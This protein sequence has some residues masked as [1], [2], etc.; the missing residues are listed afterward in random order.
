MSDEEQQQLA[1]RVSALE[2]KANGTDPLHPHGNRTAQPKPDPEMAKLSA[3]VGRL[4]NEVATL[5]L[6]QQ[7]LRGERGI[8]IDRN[9]IRGPEVPIAIPPRTITANVCDEITGLATAQNI[10]VYP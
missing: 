4:A 3:Q 10:V 9:V 1:N 7:G 2:N 6:W 8:E 5:K